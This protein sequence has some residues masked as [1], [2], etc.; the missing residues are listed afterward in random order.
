M[1]LIT[2]IPNIPSDQICRNLI[3]YCPNKIPIFPK[4]PTPQFLLNLRILLKYLTRRYTLQHPHHLRNRIPR[5]KTQKY[6]H[7]IRRY[8]HLLDFKSMMPSYFLKNLLNLLPY[9]FSLNPFSI[10]RRPYQMILC[11]VNSMCTPPNPHEDLYTMF[12]LPSADAPFIP[13]HRTGF[14][15]AN[16]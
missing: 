15:G 11:I 8:P 4:L 2:M 13:A 6:M 5:R 10:L 3:P 16:G 12:S 1:N 9:I 14:S 7:M